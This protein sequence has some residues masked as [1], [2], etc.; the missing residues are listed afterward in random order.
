MGR[1]ALFGLIFVSLVD[2][3]RVDFRFIETA[4][5]N[6]VF[7]RLPIVDKLKSDKEPFRVMDLTRQTFTSKNYFALYGIEQLV[8]YHGAQLK[9][10][11]EFIGGLS[12][13]RLHGNQDI[14]L[15]PFHLTGTKYIIVDRGTQMPEEQG[16]KKVYDNEVV[17]YE[18]PRPMR[19]ASI[20]HAYQLASNAPSDLDL[21][22]NET[23]PYMNVLLLS[24]APEYQPALPDSGAPESVTIVE[25]EIARQRY[26]AEL[27][28]P[29]LLFVSENYFPGWKVKVDGVEK[30]LLK[31]HHTFRAVSLDKGSHEVEFYWDWPRYT[32][33]VWR[34]SL[35][36]S[37]PVSVSPPAFSMNA[38]RKETGLTERALVLLPTYNEKDNI[39]KIA[40]Q[41][42]AVDPRIEVLVVDDNSP[43]G[44]GQIA[45][46]LAAENPRIQVLHRAGKQGLGRA[47]IAGFHYGI[48]KKYDY[49]FEMDADFSHQP[50]YLADHLKNIQDCD[51]SLGSR[52]I[53]GGGVENWPKTRWAISYYAN[54]YSRIS[55]WSAS[56]RRYRRL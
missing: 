3:W 53:K 28:T 10:F 36:S 1:I 23:F 26:K 49:I 45:D 41:M 24:E 16:L 18:T 2:L 13:S 54:V 33:S 19:R 47:Y 9:S 38:R 20:Y 43:D 5:Y 51:I 32:G 42:L 8:G 52:Y 40:R 22:Y 29:G 56:A 31:A 34:R 15:R 17:V 39:E 50:K 48:E 30:K 46:R 12:Y 6:R 7:P 55:D 35:P 44:T 14:N 27:S 21:L 4:D 25:H 37:F 11:D